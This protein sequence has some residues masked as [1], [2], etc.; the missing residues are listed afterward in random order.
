MYTATQSPDGRVWKSLGQDLSDQT[1]S[2]MISILTNPELSKLFTEAELMMI[3]MSVK[4]NIAEKAEGTIKMVS[5]DFADRVMAED[6]EGK[7]FR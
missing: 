4:T 2:N 3:K 7:K 6:Y 1:I 5:E